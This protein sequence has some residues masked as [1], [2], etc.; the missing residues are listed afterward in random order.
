M[1]LLTV[2]AVVALVLASIG[3]LRDHVSYSVAAAHRE[4]GVRM[5]LGAQTRNV[6]GLVIGQG[7]KL[8]L[9]G[10]ALGLVASVARLDH[11]YLL[12]GERHRSATFAA[13][14]L[15]LAGVALWL[16]IPARRAAK[17]DR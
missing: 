12:S 13:I 3:D 4:I 10:V 17:L 6:L 1:L 11:K 2:F 8:A 16:F 5:A 14:A 7:M 9:V 15:L